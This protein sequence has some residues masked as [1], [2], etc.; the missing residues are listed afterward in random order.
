MLAGAGGS[1][2]GVWNADFAA[3]ALLVCLAPAKRAHHDLTAELRVFNVETRRFR[4]A[5]STGKGDQKQCFV[6]R[7]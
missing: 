1:V 4:P 3:R 5:E 2:F 7:D 6:T